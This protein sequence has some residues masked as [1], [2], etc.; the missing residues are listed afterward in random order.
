[1][2]GAAAFASLTVGRS[3]ASSTMPTPASLSAPA[4]CAA[5]PVRRAWEGRA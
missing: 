2:A 1:M 3:L 4:L 5:L